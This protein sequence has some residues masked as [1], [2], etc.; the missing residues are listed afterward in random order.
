[1]E[2]FVFCVKIFEPI[3]R[4]WGELWYGLPLY[5]GSYFMCFLIFYLGDNICRMIQIR[6]KLFFLSQCLIL[7]HG[8]ASK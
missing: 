8:W 6:S 4:V 1:M 7:K 3:Q 2:I 5:Y